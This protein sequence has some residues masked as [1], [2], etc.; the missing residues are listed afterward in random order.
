MRESA[1]KVGT[2]TRV[3]SPALDG[4]WVYTISGNRGLDGSL[5]TCKQSVGL[6]VKNVCD[7]GH[8]KKFCGM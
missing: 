1:R 6:G 5:V 3:P 8:S 4:H 2:E 7:D